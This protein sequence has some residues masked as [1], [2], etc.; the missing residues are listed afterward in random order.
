[1][2]QL[3]RECRRADERRRIARAVL[4]TLMRQ[5]QEVMRAENGMLRDLKL[6]RLQ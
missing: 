3:V 5:L 4:M 1:M 2:R 6:A